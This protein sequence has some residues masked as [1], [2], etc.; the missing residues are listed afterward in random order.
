MKATAVSLAL[1]ALQNEEV[2]RR[3]KAAGA[4]GLARLRSWNKEH[5]PELKVPDASTV[6]DL[7][8]KATRQGRLE[9]RVQRLTDA[10]AALRAKGEQGTRLDWLAQALDEA[11][12]SLAIARS[13]PRDKRRQAHETID[14]MLTDIEEV[15]FASLQRPYLEPGPS[16]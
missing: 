14:T 9:L 6:T 15:L 16:D 2:Q 7:T 13:L 4:E 11:H 10:E 8:R 1:T 5:G 12:T 3:L